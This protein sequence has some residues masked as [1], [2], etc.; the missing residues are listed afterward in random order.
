MRCPVV[1]LASCFAMFALS[2]PPLS[3]VVLA[4]TTC[5]VQRLLSPTFHICPSHSSIT[6]ILLTFIL[7]REAGTSTTGSSHTGH[8]PFFV[9]EGVG[10]STVS[11]P[12]FVVP[13]GADT[14]TTSSF[15]ATRRTSWLLSSLSG[16][17]VHLHLGFSCP[18]CISVA[19]D[20][21]SRTSV[22]SPFLSVRC[23]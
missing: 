14:L 4:P 1:P 13:E 8:F 12:L 18:R 2:R 7:A 9:L 15:S 16:V 17:A 10:P 23:S 22:L 21:S 5:M 6:F 20:V 19:A 3:S 11:N